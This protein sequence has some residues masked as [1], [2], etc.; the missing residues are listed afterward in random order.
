M[1]RRRASLKGFARRAL[2]IEGQRAGGFPET[3]PGGRLQ[4]P[5]KFS[6]HTAAN[7]PRPTSDRLHPRRARAPQPAAAGEY[8]IPAAGRNT[9]REHRQWS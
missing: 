7:S 3:Q 5:R 4:Q 8:G 6:A 2:R 1:R 9:V